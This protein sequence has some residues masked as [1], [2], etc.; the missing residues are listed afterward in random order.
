MSIAG[1]ILA[2]VM[3]LIVVAWTIRPLLASAPDES[4]FLDRQRERAL[5]YY[6][7]VLTNVR[8]LDE[9]HGTG[10]I[11]PE[12]YQAEREMWVSRGVRILQ[13]LDEL[14]E[15]HSF[16]ADHDAGDGDIDDAIETA[17]E[18]Y[19]MKQAELASSGSA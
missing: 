6:E 13:L 2:I 3:L 7:R 18:S 16:V 12:E 8:D 17:V 1:L 5:A 9:D 11:S 4:A 14:D 15:Q 10:K 19:R